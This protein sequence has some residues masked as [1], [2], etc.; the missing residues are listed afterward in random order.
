MRFQFD[1]RQPY[2]T[3]AIEA[4]T[5]LF[6]GQ[7]ADA[8]QLVTKLEDYSPNRA[9]DIPGV[10][11]DA[12]D[13]SVEIGAYGNNLVLDE[14]MIAVNLLRVQDR[15][16]LEVND[17]LV[18]GLQFDI[19]METGTGKT[20]VYLRTA[21]ELASK[22]RFNK[23]IILVPSVAIREGVKTSIQLMREHFRHLYPQ[24]NMDV[25]VYSGDRAE[26]VRDFATATS[27]QFLVMT[28]D[29]IKGDKNTR[30]IHQARDKLSGLRPL[31]FLQ[32]TRPIVIMDE[33]QNMESQL[34]QSAVADLNPLCTLR[35]SA[36]HRTTRN[37]VYRL[38]PLDAHRL[39]L[40]KKIVVSDA[41]EMGSAAKPYVKLLEVKRDPSFKV[42]L[43]LVVRKKDGGF[44]KKRS[45]PPKAPIWSGSLV[46]IRRMRGIGGSTRSA[47]NPSRSSSPTTDICVWVRRLVTTRTL[48]SGR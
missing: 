18:D 17:T 4:V 48:C 23:F 35:Y 40:V 11:P 46:G 42:S 24:L 14:E 15:N 9:L 36:T 5:D 47:S 6:D 27:L 39:E 12:L 31:D 16:G 43:E 26:E 8:D 20:Y 41:L 13:L 19:E 45:P 30:I 32:A 1:P 44:A 10:A 33:P 7:P 25:T 28:I 29:S 34:S 2:Q 21:F 37:V 22:Y 38:D 3:S